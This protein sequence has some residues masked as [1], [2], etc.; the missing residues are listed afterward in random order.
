MLETC[1]NV[2]QKNPALDPESHALDDVDDPVPEYKEHADVINKPED[3]SPAQLGT[4]KNIDIDLRWTVLCD[5]FL[6]LI[7]GLKLRRS[8]P[9][10]S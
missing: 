2:Y 1:K 9:N 7:I 10:T 8:F 5:L 4:G 6:V 3:M